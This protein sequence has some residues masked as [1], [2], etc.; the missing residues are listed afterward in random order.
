MIANEL[1]SKHVR[2]L[3]TFDISKGKLTVI[4]SQGVINQKDISQKT[5][6]YIPG[7]PFK[8]KIGESASVN[9]GFNEFVFRQVQVF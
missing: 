8:M 1:V 4:D 6:G 5:M 3:V 9:H 7:S 2:V